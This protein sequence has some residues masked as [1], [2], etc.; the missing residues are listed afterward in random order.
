MGYA[1]VLQKEAPSLL[2]LIGVYGTISGVLTT[3]GEFILHHIFYQVIALFSKS[4]KGRG[5]P[6]LK[7]WGTEVRD[8]GTLIPSWLLGMT[9]ATII[10]ASAW[11]F[12][13]E[14]SRAVLDRVAI[15]PDPWV[16]D[17]LYRAQTALT[18]VNRAIWALG[19]M[20]TI[21]GGSQLLL[22]NFHNLTHGPGERRSLIP[23]APA[24]AR[25]RL[26]QTVSDLLDFLR[27]HH[28]DDVVLT[29][30]APRDSY[31]GQSPRDFDFTFLVDL[32]EED[33]ALIQAPIRWNEVMGKRIVPRLE[34]VAK[35]LGI[36]VDALLG[37]QARFREMDL[38]YAGPFKRTTQSGT[39]EMSRY[40]VLYAVDDKRNYRTIPFLTVNMVGLLPNGEWIGDQEGLRDLE[41]KQLRLL[42]GIKSITPAYVVRIAYLMLRF[43]PGVA[44][45]LQEVLDRFKKQS[46][47]DPLTG[48]Q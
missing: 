44:D 26:P 43:D 38:H 2:T 40:G 39:T 46:S 5:P 20:V 27:L 33:K 9:A 8:L 4:V 29:G 21:I 13:P 11:F 19:E 25:R 1:F 48:C 24:P 45:S 37:K 36:T 18:H 10:I 16:V 41:N 47:E 31:R 23:A 3:L 6:R 12:V 34:A 22:H 30:G 28:L 35:A 7:W 15:S 42:P 32:S 17:R 14:I